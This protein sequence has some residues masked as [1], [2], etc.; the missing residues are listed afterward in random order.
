M[1][2]GGTQSESAELQVF[3]FDHAILMV[4]QKNKNEQQKV[5]RKVS[6]PRRTFCA[7]A[8]FVFSQPI[9]LELLVVTAIDEVTSARTGAVR[10]KSLLSRGTNNRYLS[11]P[12]P[13]IDKN[14][15][16]G[17]AMTFIHLGRRG[18]QITLWSA[19]WA[20][21][22]KWL[23]KIEGR[24]N[25]LRERSLVF[26]TLPL[27][28][29]YFV[30][31]NR[32][33]CAAPFGT[34][35]FSLAATRADR[36]DRQWKSNGLWNGQRSLPRRPPRT[37][38]GSRQGHL[39]SERHSARRTRGARNP[40]RSRWFVVLRQLLV[41]LAD[42][43]RSQT[44]QCRPSSWTIS[45]QQMRSEQRNEPER[46]PR[47]RRSL[48]L[49]NVSVGRS[50]VSSSLVRSR[51]RS[52]PSNQSIKCAGRNSRR[53]GNSC[54]AATSRYVSSRSVLR[55]SWLCN[56]VDGLRAQEFYIPT[57]S[58]SVHFLKS[59]LCVGCTKG[60]EIV[61]LET[62][63]TQGLLDPADSSLDFIQKRENARPIAIYR[64]EGDFLLCYD[65]QSFSLSS[66]KG[67]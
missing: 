51:V 50:C 58:S 3:L 4:K 1:K 5:Y 65:G 32:V 38:Q 62:L 61:D 21:R 64:V 66:A 48:K 42:V 27:S 7:T 67:Y 23:E 14:S 41:H 30:G 33:T 26:D 56:D 25:E 60:F 46:F 57:E 24:Q 6:L 20:G 45:I 12:P 15:K 28:E 63:D 44:R 36:N 18:Y 59:K 52:R 55:S 17:F 31:T 13:G 8:H 39:L 40:H 54:R 16:Q 43:S 34:S 37:Q 29:G 11:N 19:S 9:P 10:P 53:F 2:R 22:K 47:M 49:V 35:L